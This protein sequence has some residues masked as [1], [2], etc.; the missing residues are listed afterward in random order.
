MILVNCSWILA[1]CENPGRVTR[2]SAF[3][4]R[5]ARNGEL[6]GDDYGEGHFGLDRV[7]G[8]RGARVKRIG[9]VQ[10]DFCSCGKGDVAGGRSGAWRGALGKRRSVLWS[11][12]GRRCR[13]GWLRRRLLRVGRY[14]QRYSQCQYISHFSLLNFLVRSF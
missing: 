6:V 10:L 3:D 5:A 1:R 11:V 8:L 13:S 12:A 9:E 7:T 2:D 4:V 14:R